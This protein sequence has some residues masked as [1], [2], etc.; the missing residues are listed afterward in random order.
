[1]RLRRGEQL[2]T[3]S[4]AEVPEYLKRGWVSATTTDE[5]AAL[6]RAQERGVSES[7]GGVKNTVLAGAQGAAAALTLGGSRLIESDDQRRNTDEHGYAD[8]AGQFAGTLLGAGLSGVGKAGSA[9]AGLQNPLE[10]LGVAKGAGFAGRVALGTVDNVITQM[11][12]NAIE[13]HMRG[14]DVTDAV[15]NGGVRDLIFGGVIGTAGHGA[16]AV[17]AK[18]A[19]SRLAQSVEKAALEEASTKLSIPVVEHVLDNDVYGSIARTPSTIDT[20][21]LSRD[22]ATHAEERRAMKR[23]AATADKQQEMFDLGAQRHEDGYAASKAKYDETVAQLPGGVEAYNSAIVEHN[24]SN[25]EAWSSEAGRKIRESQPYKEMVQLIGGEEVLAA[26][27][28]EAKARVMNDFLARNKVRGRVSGAGE[29]KLEPRRSLA[30]AWDE[31]IARLGDNV[32]TNKQDFEE[33]AEAFFRDNGVE[34]KR[35]AQVYKGQDAADNLNEGVLMEDPKTL[36][37]LTADEQALEYDFKGRAFG[38]AEE[39]VHTVDAETARQLSK[40]HTLQIM[41]SLEGDPE[42]YEKFMRLLSPQKRAWVLAHEARIIEHDIS[43]INQTHGHRVEGVDG[44]EFT[45]R[46]QAEF[47]RAFGELDSELNP[48]P[49]T[50]F[51]PPHMPVIPAPPTPKK[52]LTAP[53]KTPYRGL[54]PAQP[55]EYYKTLEKQALERMDEKVAVLNN[56]NAIRKQFPK[57]QSQFLHMSEKEAGNLYATVRAASSSKSPVLAELGAQ[58]ELKARKLVES[59][60]VDVEKTMA[61]MEGKDIWDILE[62]T[63]TA[64]AESKLSSKARAGEKAKLTEATKAYNDK[65]GIRA[66]PSETATPMKTVAQVGGSRLGVAASTAAGGGVLGGVLGFGFGGWLGGSAIKKLLGGG[67]KKSMTAAVLKAKAIRGQKIAKFFEKIGEHGA[68][69]SSITLRTK[70]WKDFDPLRMSLDGSVD[71]STDPQRLLRNRQQELA[72]SA[73]DPHSAAYQAVKDIAHSQP[74]VANTMYNAQVTAYQRLGEILRTT[75]NYAG[76][77]SKQARGT[78]L[79][80]AAL[81][82]VRMQMFA[83]QSP[84]DAMTSMLETGRID[85]KAVAI[86]REISPQSYNEMVM[87][88]LKHGNE[89]VG[90]DE[91]GYPITRF[92]KMPNAQKTAYANFTGLELNPMASPRSVAFYHSK[93]ST[94]RQESADKAANSKG[95]VQPAPGGGSMMELASETQQTENR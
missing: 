39:T 71:E 27:S 79:S 63:R 91:A 76:Y 54:S 86:A 57:S 12:Q 43:K 64:A 78:N 85:P 82:K 2:I 60:G 15:V 33:M 11:P 36:R 24:A 59:A 28:G 8:M 31:H 84:L 44:S 30:D 18:R 23:R 3:V 13:A 32:P 4:D 38:K 50:A 45:N 26:M 21:P 80:D 87:G 40:S 35:H 52:L 65:W 20:K 61:S 46:R 55:G 95:R 93:Y 75:P 14:E 94:L 88:V 92:D 29:F 47:K 7:F 34:M 42:G 37:Q 5:N 1:M 53:E 56:V 74:D 41:K 58:M 81:D 48:V 10:A 89:V 62:H 72:A 9:V 67:G 77:S 66:E 73:N 16:A 25:Y 69:F 90:E 83:I 22:I 6:D 19:E 68:Q 70:P 49:L 51:S 17:Y